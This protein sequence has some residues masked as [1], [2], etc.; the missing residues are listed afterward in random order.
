MLFRGRQEKVLPCQKVLDNLRTSYCIVPTAHR[1][2]GCSFMEERHA[3]CLRTKK[4]GKKGRR[5]KNPGQSPPCAPISPAHIDSGEGSKEKE[6]LSKITSQQRSEGEEKRK[7]GNLEEEEEGGKLCKKYGKGREGGR[8]KVPHSGGGGGG[9][10]DA[11]VYHLPSLFSFASAVISHR[12]QRT[13]LSPNVFRKKKL[14]LFFAHAMQFQHIQHSLRLYQFDCTI[15][16]SSFLSLAQSLEKLHS[17]AFFSKK[18]FIL[19]SKCSLVCQI[20]HSRPSFTF[21]SLF[22]LPPPAPL[23]K[24]GKEQ[25]LLSLRTGEACS[26]RCSQCCQVLSY[27]WVF[28]SPLKRKETCFCLFFRLYFCTFGPKRGIFR[29]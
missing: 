27:F 25:R 3:F 24:E 28:L 22:L 7:K 10:R 14:P 20:S 21:P 8:E 29:S 23:K 12:R 5:K 1:T 18:A 17:R 26:L 9:R 2:R 16:Q 13:L 4:V 15:H 6:G 19:F 11:F